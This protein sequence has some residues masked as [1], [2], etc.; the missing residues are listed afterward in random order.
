[1]KWTT[2]LFF[3]L[4][5]A[6]YDRF[7]PQGR[8]AGTWDCGSIKLALNKDGTYQVTNMAAADKPKWEGSY[9]IKDG[10][11]GGLDIVWTGD[12]Q[13]LSP[14]TNIQGSLDHEILLTGESPSDLKTCLR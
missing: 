14:Y 12:K 8:I 3:I 10:V 7:S 6:G 2:P 4:A 9:S 11:K 5:L 1:M 13:P